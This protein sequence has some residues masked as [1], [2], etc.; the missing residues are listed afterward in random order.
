MTEMTTATGAFVVIT[1]FRPEPALSTLRELRVR[2]AATGGALIRRRN[3]W[4]VPDESA[5]W[6]AGLKPGAYT[7]ALPGLFL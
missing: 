5:K 7:G 2:K 6:C 1:R 4:R 3:R